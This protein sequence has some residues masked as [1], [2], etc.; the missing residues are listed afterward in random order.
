MKAIITA[1]RN[2]R[3]NIEAGAAALFLVAGIVVAT[4]LVAVAFA[5]AQSVRSDQITIYSHSSSV[6]GG[7]ERSYRHGGTIKGH[8]VV[9]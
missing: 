2:H 5:S 1:L 6:A 3:E 4:G 7:L 8:Q 9:L